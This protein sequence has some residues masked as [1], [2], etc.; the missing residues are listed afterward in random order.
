MKKHFKAYVTGFKGSK[1]LRVEL[2]GTKN[3]KE[4]EEIVKNFL[5]K[6]K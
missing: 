5:K 3:A 1:E 4:V 6:T 2:M